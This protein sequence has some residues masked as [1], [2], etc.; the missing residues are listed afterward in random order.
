M[1]GSLPYLLT[2]PNPINEKAARTVAGVVAGL[3]ILALATGLHWLLLVIAYGFLA[4]A[5]TGPKLSPLGRFAMWFAR[6]YLGEPRYVAGPPK[7]FAQGIGAVVTT[8]GS[9]CLVAGWS[10]GA[11]I[12]LSVIIVAA[13]LE[14]VFGLCVGCIVFAGL[15]RAG[16]IPDEICE[17]CADITRGSA[18]HSA[19]SV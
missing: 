14:S 4:R 9:V 18:K 15:M 3:A 11:I 10:T 7:R 13:T 6:R 2:F 16:L 19:H 5:A 1:P 12:A 17:A 8:G